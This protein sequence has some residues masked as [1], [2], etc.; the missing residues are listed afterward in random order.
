VSQLGHEF[1][2]L[3]SLAVAQLDGVL[4]VVASPKQ[5]REQVFCVVLAVGVVKLRQIFAEP[6]ALLFA[7]LLR[8][9]ALGELIF[10]L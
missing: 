3:L 6:I 9:F 1:F 4:A 8:L 7:L 2:L 5:T 10:G